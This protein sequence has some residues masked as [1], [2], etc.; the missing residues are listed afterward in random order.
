MKTIRY[1]AAFILLAAGV[2]HFLLFKQDPLATG[3]ALVLAFGIIYF[4]IGIL[5]FL[6]IKYSSVMG[7]IFPLIGSIVGLKIID[8]TEVNLL[9]GIM[10]IMDVVILILCLIL[11]WNRWKKAR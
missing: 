3:S 7:I 1:I 2:L 4:V 11:E 9:V 5:L 8:P 10:G 6:K